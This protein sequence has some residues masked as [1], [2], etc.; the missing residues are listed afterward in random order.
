MDFYDV[1]FAKIMNG[2]GGGGSLTR[3][4]RFGAFARGLALSK[5]VTSHQE[6]PKNSVFN[7]QASA[8]AA[9]IAPIP[10]EGYV[11]IVTDSTKYS[12]AAYDVQDNTPV[13]STYSPN[14]FKTYYMGGDKTISWVAS[15]SVTTP[16][17]MVALK[18]NDDT[19][20]TAAEL[21]NGA[22]AVFTYTKSN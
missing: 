21:K 20:F 17:V 7:T 5:S 2:G 1:L 18:K 3:Q 8:R 11:F 10:N 15:D 14:F 16:Y 4:Q 13:D 9:M 12:I 22:E 6:Q 19:E